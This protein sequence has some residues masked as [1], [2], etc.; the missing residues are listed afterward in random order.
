MGKDIKKTKPSAHQDPAMS[1]HHLEDL[2]TLAGFKDVFGIK[3]EIVHPKA[4]T[5][6]KCSAASKVAGSEAHRIYVVNR[7]I[8]W[9]FKESVERAIAKAVKNP[10]HSQRFAGALRDPARRLDRSHPIAQ[11]CRYNKLKHAFLPLNT[12]YDFT[13]IRGSDYIISHETPDLA[14]AH[15]ATHITT[16]ASCQALSLS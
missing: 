10:I 6:E 2:A 13:S 14:K 5:Q 16:R 9:R 1:F 11:T 7:H 12:V 3:N 8:P 15:R 4:S